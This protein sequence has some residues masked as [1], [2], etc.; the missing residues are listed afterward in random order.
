MRALRKPNGE[1][2]IYLGSPYSDSDPNVREQR[3]DAVCKAAAV[4][5]QRGH[6]ILSP[7]CHSHPI[8]KHGLP[9]DWV[10]WKKYDSAILKR[11]DELWVLM[12]PGWE[13]SKGLQAEIKIA[14]EMGMPVEF[15]EPCNAAT[16]TT[17]T[18]TGAVEEVGQ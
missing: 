17:P 13:S 16:E 8:A 9:T 10:F 4:L 5:M 12:L 14:R 15:V 2:T 18:D 3:F 1:C 6:L 7:I 11:C